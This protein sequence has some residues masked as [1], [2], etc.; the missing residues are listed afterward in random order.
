VI[1]PHFALFAGGLLVPL[2]SISLVNKLS[3][4]IP[5]IPE[6]SRPFDP[7]LRQMNR[8]PMPNGIA[9]VPWGEPTVRSIV[10]DNEC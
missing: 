7:Q 6:S 3:K 4:T 1:N 5:F 10:D 8:S 9:L 2:D